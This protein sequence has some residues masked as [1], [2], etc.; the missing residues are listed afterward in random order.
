M[1]LT[2]IAQAAPRTKASILPSRINCSNL[3]ASA[4]SQPMFIDQL[5]LI[6][7]SRKAMA[8]QRAGRGFAESLSS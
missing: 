5:N 3:A 8:I 6:Y 2:A 4:V 1:H 7:A